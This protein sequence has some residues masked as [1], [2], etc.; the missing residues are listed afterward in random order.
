[1]DA[2]NAINPSQ[3]TV[4]TVT[5]GDRRH[6]L[7]PVLRAALAQ[8]VGKIIVV[9]NGTSWN[10]DALANAMGSKVIVLNMDGNVGSAG[11]YSEGIALAM[12]TECKAIWLLDDDNLPK[13]DCLKEL[14]HATNLADSEKFVAL[15]ARPRFIANLTAFATKESFAKKSN[16]FLGF[17]VLEI[18]AKLKKLFTRSQPRNISTHCADINI[19]IAPYGGMLFHKSLPYDIGLPKAELCLYADDSEYA[20]R[21]VHSS[22]SIR[23]ICSAVV[24]DL[25]N[26]EHTFHRK[27]GITAWLDA[28]TF[29]LYYGMRNHIWFAFYRVCK[30]KI[31]FLFNGLIFFIILVSLGALQ[32]KYRVITTI[33]DAAHDGLSSDLGENHKYLLPGNETKNRP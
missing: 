1:M 19:C 2:D 17:H 13:A 22:Y 29:R 24:D 21:M 32:G 26:W 23:L 3:V 20:W 28:P 15:A 30:N 25:D 10:V 16:Y 8:E 31:L 14:L 4:V 33:Y 7:E 18:P 5:Y 9:N 6:L 12:E 11:G 27:F